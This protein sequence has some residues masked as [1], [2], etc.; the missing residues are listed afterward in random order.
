MEPYP[1]HYSRRSRAEEPP[2]DPTLRFVLDELQKM[3][4]RLRHC[5]KGRCFGLER[6]V[7]ESE[8]RFISLEMARTESESGRADMEKRFEG[9][10]LEV[11][12]LNHSVESES[13]ANN[14]DKSGIFV[15]ESA[16][17]SSTTG[18]AVDGPDGHRVE[19]SS[20]DH[21]FGSAHAHPHV[22]ANGM[23]QS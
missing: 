16:P 5:I 8:E 6:H 11:H 15:A 23:T 9:L 7:A 1:H 13:L 20:R 3:E 18:A 2:V 4:I 12:R 19:H 21:E 17:P 22:P 10:K 14:H